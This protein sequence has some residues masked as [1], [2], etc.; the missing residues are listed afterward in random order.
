MLRLDEEWGALCSLLTRGGVRLLRVA[1]CNVDA[2]AMA[3][4]A[5]SMTP[6]LVSLDLAHNDIGHSLVPEHGA[7][8]EGGCSVLIRV[9]PCGVETH[10]YGP[11]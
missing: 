2:L 7:V 3:T 9:R 5:E 6:R 4:L 8:G 1:S 10:A 11:G